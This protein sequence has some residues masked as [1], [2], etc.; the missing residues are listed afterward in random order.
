M[1]STL[2]LCNQETKYYYPRYACSV[3]CLQQHR[4]EQQAPD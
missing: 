1:S 4:E 2:C 3:A